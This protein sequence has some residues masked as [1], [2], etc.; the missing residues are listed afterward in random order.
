MTEVEREER[1][2]GTWLIGGLFLLGL[3]AASYF[4]F[5]GLAGDPQAA[6][7][8]LMAGKDSLSQGDAAA[9][10][11]ELENAARKNPTS[12]EIQFNLGLAYTQVGRYQ[13]AAQAFETA[14]TLDADVSTYSNL[15]VVYYKMGRLEDAVAQYQEALNLKPNDAEVRSNL[16]AAY[17][18]L[19]R[20]ED[21]QAEYE[22]A[23]A[24]SPGLAEA[25]YGL[26]MVYAAKGEKQKAIEA[27][28]Q[29]LELDTGRDPLARS[30][31]EKQLQA[32]RS[33]TE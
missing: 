17:L 25:H 30:E 15:G 23:L 5:V 6:Q 29:F 8:H 16:A 4:V 19:G 2:R 13:E 26:G 28:Q 11:Q 22:R 1:N 10:V 27:L 33:A 31:A 20:L 18:Q 32:L 14:L 7:E 24:L 3:I 21:A 9:A 12:K